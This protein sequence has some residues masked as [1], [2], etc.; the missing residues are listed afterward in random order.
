MGRMK[1]A[2]AS[3][4]PWSTSLGRSAGE[5]SLVFHRAL[6][7]RY[8]SL[9]CRRIPELGFA[10]QSLFM[11]LLC[12]RSQGCRVEQTASLSSH[13]L[14][15]TGTHHMGLKGDSGYHWKFWSLP[16]SQSVPLLLYSQGVLSTNQ[17]CGAS[18]PEMSSID[19]FFFLQFEESEA[20]RE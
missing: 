9:G 1:N 5:G 19:T 2:F 14:E 12:V 20:Q 16:G 7:F 8:G 18:L 10:L 15:S 17:A 13:G 4:A 6:I 3:Q 11:L